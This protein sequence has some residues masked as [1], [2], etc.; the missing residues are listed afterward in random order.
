MSRLITWILLLACS[1]TAVWSGR[2]GIALGLGAVKALL[3]GFEFMEL[4]YAHRLHAT[5]FAIFVILMALGA[6]LLAH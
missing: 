4:R 2:L 5:A 6:G 1:I 3:V